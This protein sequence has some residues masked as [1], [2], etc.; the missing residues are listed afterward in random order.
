[1]NDESRG[2][3]N[4]D[5]QINP[6]QDGELERQKDP[7]SFSFRTSTSVLISTQTYLT[8]SFNG[9]STPG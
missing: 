6:I 2:S 7:F 3:Y 5:S 8:F 4:T 9:F 1:M